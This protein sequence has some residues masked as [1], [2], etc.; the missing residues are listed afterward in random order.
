[1]PIA[2]IYSRVRLTRDNILIRINVS[3]LKLQIIKNLR[4]FFD[5][6]NYAIYRKDRRFWIAIVHSIPIIYQLRFLR[7]ISQFIRDK[8]ALSL[9]CPPERG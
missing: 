3:L 4:S 7:D 1:M 5:L 2:A 6:Y 9:A 8:P